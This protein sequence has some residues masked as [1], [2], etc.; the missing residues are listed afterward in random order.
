MTPQHLAAVNEPGNSP[1]HSI[2]AEQALLGAILAN[3]AALDA[4]ESIVAVD[5]FYEPIHSFLF[6]HMLRAKE[7]GRRITLQLVG[8][9]LSERVK[10]QDICGLTVSQYVARLAAEAT[11]IIN[12]PDFARVIAED[13]DRRKII[14]AADTMKAAAYLKSPVGPA[15]LGLVRKQPLRA[16]GLMKQL[17]N[18]IRH[19]NRRA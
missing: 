7:Q 19:G 9:L 11:T 15:D 14:E 13:A 17:C 5:D 10:R 2:E 3:D 18:S 16:I 1:P 4:V 12:A 8:A 6:E